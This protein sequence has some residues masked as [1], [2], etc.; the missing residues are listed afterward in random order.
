MNWIIK[1]KMTNSNLLHRFFKK[2]HEPKVEAEK[3]LLQEI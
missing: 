2:Y 3:E 1:S